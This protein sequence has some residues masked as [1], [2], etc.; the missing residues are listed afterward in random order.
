MTLRV[1]WPGPLVLIWSHF[2]RAGAGTLANTP[3]KTKTMLECKEDSFSEEVHAGQG[4][5]TGTCG[6]EVECISVV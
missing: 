1:K 4:L 5:L 3:P 2:M 6:K